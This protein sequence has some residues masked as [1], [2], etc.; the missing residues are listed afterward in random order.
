VQ[1]NINLATLERLRFPLPP[2]SEQRRIADILAALDD[3][4]EL[5]RRMSQTLESMARALFNSWFV[6]FDPVRA[7]AEGRDLG[8][9]PRLAAL[10]PD[11]FENSELGEVP[12]GWHAARLSDLVTLNPSRA[13][14]QGSE[15]P[16]LDM[17]NMPTSG[18]TP[19]DI[20]IRPFS[21]GSRFVNGDTL[22]ARITPCLENGKTAFV[23]FLPDGAVGWG[24][25]EFLVLRTKPPLPPEFAYCLARSEAFRDF[26][27]NGMTGSSGRQRVSADSL[28]E[29]P[30]AQPSDEIATLF[31]RQASLLLTKARYAHLEGSALSMQREA[32]LPVLMA[33]RHASHHPGGGHE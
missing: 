3:K 23:D 4:I 15:S 8:L 6:D 31:G 20:T 26:A 1:D 24:S 7:K 29:Y 22:M 28:A 27:I 30:V 13:L 21:S 33:N 14:A 10:F 19:L 32:L 17:A 5:N 9:P 16:Y 25:T 12:R 11:S 2:L 18:H